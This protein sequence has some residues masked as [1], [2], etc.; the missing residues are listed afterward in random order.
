MPAL[1]QIKRD[2][3]VLREIFDKQNKGTL[4]KLFDVNLTN[5]AEEAVN[6]LSLIM[7]NY[8]LYDNLP[9]VEVNFIQN[10]QVRMLL[11]LIS[12]L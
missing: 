5:M 1:V 12:L 7:S 6:A 4:L 10:I 8:F 9:G 3:F 11:I 2:D